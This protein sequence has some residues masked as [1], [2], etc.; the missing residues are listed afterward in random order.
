MEPSISLRFRVEAPVLLFL[1]AR[2]RALEAIIFP[3]AKL[4]FSL[5]AVQYVGFFNF[6]N[7]DMFESERVVSRVTD[8]FVSITLVSRKRMGTIHWSSSGKEGKK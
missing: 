2:T 4:N 3:E 6:R 8:G 5:R 1:I 7:P